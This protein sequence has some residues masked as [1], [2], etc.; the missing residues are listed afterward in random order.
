MAVVAIAAMLLA[1]FFCCPGG[2]SWKDKCLTGCSG[3]LGAV[4]SKCSWSLFRRLTE[5]EGAWRNASKLTL[6]NLISLLKGE[7]A[8]YQYDTIYTFC[9]ASYGVEFGGN[10]F[11]MK[12][13]SWIGLAIFSFLI[14]K[15]VFKE[16]NQLKLNIYIFSS[17]IGLFLY[18]LGLLLLYVFT[19]SEWEA[20]NLASYQRYLAT[21]LI[22][23]FCFCLAVFF[24]YILQKVKDKNIANV[25]I[26]GTVYLLLL[27]LPRAELVNITFGKGEAVKSTNTLRMQYADI[28]QYLPYFD[29]H[30]DKIYFVCQNTKGFEYLYLRYLVT[31]VQVGGPSYSVGEPYS[32][33]DIMYTTDYTL[34]QWLAEIANQNVTYVYLYLID[35]QFV[36]KYGAAFEGAIEQGGLYKV[37]VSNAQ[38]S[39]K[40]CD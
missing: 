17:L 8:E 15:A 32:E 3:V 1:D 13:I 31:P 25:I 5:T 6:G 12:Y 40:K 28:E 34:E 33:G 35:E 10:M 16:I 23:I 11:Q 27:F 9:K 4:M 19:Y 38:V 29:Y 37:C 26:V 14:L 30:T 22:G 24:Y 21:Y 2:K 36:E 18:T 20:R 39:L 7:G